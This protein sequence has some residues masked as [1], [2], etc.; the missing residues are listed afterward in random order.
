MGKKKHPSE[1]AKK[2][3]KEDSTKHNQNEFWLAVSHTASSGWVQGLGV[4]FLGVSISCTGISMSAGVKIDH[5][6]PR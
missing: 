5:I 6:A 4:T 2:V 3:G 1:N